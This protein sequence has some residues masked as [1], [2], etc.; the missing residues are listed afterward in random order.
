[1]KSIESIR[2]GDRVIK[3]SGSYGEA[4]SELGRENSQKKALI[5]CEN[6]KESQ[7]G[8]I[9]FT[10]SSNIERAI[11]TRSEIDNELEHLITEEDNIEMIS[12]KDLDKI[13]LA[14]NNNAKKYI[15]KDFHPSSLLGLGGFE[16]DNHNLLLFH[17]LKKLYKNNSNL[18]LKTWISKKEEINELKSKIKDKFLEINT[19]NINPSD[20][21]SSPEDFIIPY[22]KF[23][24]R[25]SEIADKHFPER[26]WKCLQVGHDVQLDLSAMFLLE[27][28]ISLK[29]F[30]KTGSLRNYLESSSISIVN[31]K[32]IFKYR[33]LEKKIEADF[34]TI[35]KNLKKASEERKA[36]WSKNK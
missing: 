33:D 36:E 1:M 15:I 17:K 12:V 4:L 35:I 19:D 9:F 26:P 23:L 2:H 31:N 20:F 18:A 27:G 7:D 3:E 22:F 34:I 5:Y 16:K 32:I 30:E 10:T 25:I 29:A 6:I 24:K 28:E 14:K 8:T 21:T 13:E 11:D